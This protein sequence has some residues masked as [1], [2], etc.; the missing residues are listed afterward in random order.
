[1][2]LRG[3]ALGFVLIPELGSEICAGGGVEQKGRKWIRY[4]EEC[5]MDETCGEWVIFGMRKG[6]TQLKHPDPLSLDPTHVRWMIGD[7]CGTR[8]KCASVSRSVHST[9]CSVFISSLRP[10]T[11]NFP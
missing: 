3:V 10:P 1:M 8:E 5:T 4:I 6:A 11:T 2:P 7:M 9:S